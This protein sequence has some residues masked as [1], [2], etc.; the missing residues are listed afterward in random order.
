[1]KV[2]IRQFTVDHKYYVTVNGY[3]NIQFISEELN[4]AVK[5]YKRLLL[6]NEAIEN[7]FGLFVFSTRELAEYFI[8]NVID[9]IL[10]MEKLTK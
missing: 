8:E 1:M 10:I 3:G 9:P 4:L 2:E 7:S 6:K 5:K